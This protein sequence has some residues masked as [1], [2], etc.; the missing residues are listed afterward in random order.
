[1]LMKTL[2]HDFLWGGSLAAHQ[3][4]GAWDEGGKGLAIM[5]FVG[6]GSSTELRKVYDQI[7]HGVYYPNHK[8]IDFYHKYREDIK[9][10]A[11]M[12]INALRISVD[13][14][15]IYP[16]GDDEAPNEK[17][18]AY[19]HDV[20]DTLLACQIEPIITLY[21][22]EM[23]LLVARK[24][25]S[26]TSRKTVELYLR[27][28]ETMFT[29]LKGKVHKWITFNEM[30]HLDLK[31]PYAETFTYIL[32]GLRCSAMEDRD[33]SAARIAYFTSL[34]S[35]KAVRLAHAI[36]PSNQV[37]GVFGITP[38]Y[39]RTCDPADVMQSF[40]DMNADFY[41]IDAMCTG[42]YPAYKMAEYEEQG[43][44]LE[45]L[46]KDREDF[47][48][49]TIDFIGLNYYGSEVSAAK[50]LEREER[51]TFGGYRNEYLPVTP[52][53]TAIDPAGL[54]YTLNYLDRRY[55][56][57]I[58]ITENG[59]GA[60]DQPDENGQVHDTYRMD[61]LRQH[62]RELKKAVLMD[63]VDCIGYLT[64]APIDLVSATTGEM[65]KRYGFIYTDLD[66]S[67][68]GSGKR[69]PKDSYGWYREVIRSNGENL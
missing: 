41:Q 55:G 39:P 33:A 19:Y 29:S 37:G 54:R 13:W 8:G 58:L 32:T 50:A 2:K 57:P 48:E 18:L 9:L 67:G 24:Y 30:N 20:V 3:C 22:F 23:P 47:R 16:N 69:I 68:K 14:S 42:R 52:W 1:M 28:C 4:E 62:I 63:H 43:I 38:F 44:H 10:L 65:K 11:G 31:G 59:L 45:I 25:G 27:F 64:W 21:H 5:D 56:L 26:W 15:R 7:E 51:S 49:G 36:D 66:D 53:G 40:A 17:G 34:A 60:E 46:E 35:V 12:G 61:Y 6:A